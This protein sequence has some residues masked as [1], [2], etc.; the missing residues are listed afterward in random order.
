MVRDGGDILA[1]GQIGQRSYRKVR[2]AI[3]SLRWLLVLLCGHS[4]PDAFARGRYLSIPCLGLTSGRFEI[5]ANFLLA[6]ELVVA[7]KL[8]A[9]T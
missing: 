7:D 3:R 2:A 4:T 9:S 1:Y 5:T 8:K 6:E